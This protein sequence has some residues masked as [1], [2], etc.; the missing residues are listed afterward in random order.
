ME[1]EQR[2][3]DTS[4]PSISLGRACVEEAAMLCSISIPTHMHTHTRTHTH[5]LSL[6]LSHTHG[7][8]HGKTDLLPGLQQLVI[9]AV[10]L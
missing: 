1:R 6:S 4:A 9:E 5:T 3:D 7:G 8:R 2:S 10:L